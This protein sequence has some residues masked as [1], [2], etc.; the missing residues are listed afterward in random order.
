MNSIHESKSIEAVN[1]I[2]TPFRSQKS[3]NIVTDISVPSDRLP[4][5]VVAILNQILQRTFYHQS[6][7]SWRS[8]PSVIVFR[9]MALDLAELPKFETRTGQ[10]TISKDPIPSELRDPEMLNA[11]KVGCAL[12]F[13]LGAGSAYADCPGNPD[14]LGTSRVLAIDPNEYSQIGTINYE[15]TLPLKD[16]EVVLTFDDGPSSPRTAKVLDTLAAEC[17]K[18]TFFIVGEMAR[19]APELVRRA[20]S[21]GHSIGSHT[22]TH[23]HLPNLAFQKAKKEI[24]DGINSTIAALG[25]PKALSPFFRAP[26]LELNDRLERYLGSRKIAVWSID[27]Q[28]DDWEPLSADQIVALALKRIEAAHKGILLLHDP[29]SNTPAALV[30]LL[31]ELK[32]RGYKVVHVVAADRASNKSAS[33]LPQTTAPSVVP[34]PNSPFP[35]TSFQAAP[36]VPSGSV[37]TTKIEHPHATPPP[38]NAAGKESS[39]KDNPNALGTSRV[40]IADPIKSRKIGTLQFADTLPLQDHEIVLSFDDGPLSPET[41]KI[42]DI[43]ATECV[44]ATF[45]V[46]GTMVKD[47]PNSLRRAYAEGHTIGT[48]SETHPHLPKLTLK[49]AKKEIT[50]GI[51]TVAAALPEKA[52]VAPFFRAPYLETTPALDAYLASQRLMLWSIDAQADDWQNITPDQV[53]ERAITSIEKNRKGIVMLYDTE[54]QTAAAL[55]KLLMELKTR[56]YRIVHVEAPGGTIR[57]AMH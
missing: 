29:E 27:F 50:D 43:L 54:P 55:P 49:Q 45:F 35:T 46:V 2:V 38:A 37:D 36:S 21:E 47:F 30:K 52:A 33:A 23:P 11:L 5:L 31:R 57:S 8:L 3:K 40:L 14:A 15:E 28:A 26:Y 34:Q 41:D 13:I 10:T 1:L 4:S 56:G 12:T 48:G 7:L 24:D 19:D 53:V 51:A 18:A 6:M 32:V 44:K 16:H 9:L 25:D 42:L 20:Y 39:C 22:Q 17:V